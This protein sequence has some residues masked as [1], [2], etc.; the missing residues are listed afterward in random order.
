MESE[1]EVTLTK[2]RKLVLIEGDHNSQN[3]TGMCANDST[4]IV[5]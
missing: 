2:K 4:R 1:F 5:L 3:V